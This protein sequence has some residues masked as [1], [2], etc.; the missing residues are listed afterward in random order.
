[1]MGQDLLR[2]QPAAVSAEA[3]QMAE[4]AGVVG[5]A[6][7]PQR[8]SR[9]HPD[10]GGGVAGHTVVGTPSSEPHFITPSFGS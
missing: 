6:S 3:L 8:V 7:C 5:Y 4:P 1:M 9:D 10:G 2:Q